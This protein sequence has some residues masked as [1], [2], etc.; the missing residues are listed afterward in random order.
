MKDAELL[1]KL[2][3]QFEDRGAVPFSPAGLISIGIGELID[4]HAVSH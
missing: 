3:W 1:E 2:K 4:T